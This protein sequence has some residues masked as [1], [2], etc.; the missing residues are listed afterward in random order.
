MNTGIQRSSSTPFGAA[1]TT[2]PPGEY[3]IGENRF[4]KDLPSI[5]V[6]HKIPYVATVNPAYYLDLMN[7]VRKASLIEGPAYIHAYSPCPTGWRHEGR[8]AV[9]VAR[10]AVQTR[11]FPL[12][13]VIYGKYILNRK[14]NKPKPV[15]EYL[16]L[17]KRFAHLTKSEIEI[18][19]KN[20]DN[21]Y[22]RILRLSEEF[23][24]E[25]KLA[26]AFQNYIENLKSQMDEAYGNLLGDLRY[27]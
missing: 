13:E 16:K 1:T 5:A 14:V 15:T 26:N 6:S 2:S 19:Q 4:K 20:A 17:Q 11:I 22:E 24:I 7:K 10:L 18:I 21:E 25:K 8:Y 23:D 12:Y 3:S 27:L 9:K